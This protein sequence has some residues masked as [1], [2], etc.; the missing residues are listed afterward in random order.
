MGRV[1]N[2]QPECSGWVTAGGPIRALAALG[3]FLMVKG[4]GA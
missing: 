3:F 2:E 1:L 4:M